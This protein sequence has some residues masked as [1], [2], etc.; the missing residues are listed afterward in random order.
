MVQAK[1]SVMAIVSKTPMLAVPGW[2]ESAI[3]ANDPMVVRAL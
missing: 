1:V 2:L 3:L